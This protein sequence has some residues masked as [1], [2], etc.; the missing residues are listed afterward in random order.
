MLRLQAPGSSAT[1]SRLAAAPCDGESAKPPEG[2][3][4]ASAQLL[5]QAPPAAGQ[6]PGAADA[7]SAPAEAQPVEEATGR[8]AKVESKEAAM[9]MDAVAA[10]VCS[11]AVCFLGF[12]VRVGSKPWKP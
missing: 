1:E 8:S 6:L 10:L 4:P 7:E 2:G 11:Y 5:G 9:A 3:L 12:K